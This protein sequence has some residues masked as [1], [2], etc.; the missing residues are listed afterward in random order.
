MFTPNLRCSL[1]R[2]KGEYSLLMTSTISEKGQV[3]IPKDIRDKLGLSAGTILSFMEENGRL[4]AVKQAKPNPFARWSGKGKLPG[5]R[6]TDSYLNLV[7][8]GHSR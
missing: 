5:N 1:L 3:T 7:R 4:I 2:G 6:D 8:D